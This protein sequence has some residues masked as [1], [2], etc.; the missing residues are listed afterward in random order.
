[1]RSSSLSVP[2]VRSVSDTASVRG[3]GRAEEELDGVSVFA[4]DISGMKTSPLTGELGLVSTRSSSSLSESSLKSG[5]MVGDC[6][7]FGY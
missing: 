7:C 5:A 6:V 3:A 2:L 4:K 1:M